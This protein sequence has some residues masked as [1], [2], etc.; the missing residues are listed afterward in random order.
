L[1]PFETKDPEELEEGSGT[2]GADIKSS[3]DGIPNVFPNLP[4]APISQQPTQ[5]QVQPR[6]VAGSAPQIPQLS[7]RPAVPEGGLGPLASN[8]IQSAGES[9]PQPQPIPDDAQVRRKF[10]IRS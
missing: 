5:A 9:L 8:S 6:V 4:K 3:I 7:G 2:G 1:L 10:V